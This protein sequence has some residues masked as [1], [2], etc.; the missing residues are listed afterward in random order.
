MKT[1]YSDEDVHTLSVDEVL[2]IFQ[3]N[4]DTGL[5]KSEAAKRT[6]HFGLY[7]IHL[8]QGIHGTSGLHFHQ[9]S[10]QSIDQ[11]YHQNSDSFN[12]IL[13]V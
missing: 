1:K 11:N 5:S 12:I 4:A 6:N 2:D 13:K 9:K 8:L 3:T 10:N 7:Y